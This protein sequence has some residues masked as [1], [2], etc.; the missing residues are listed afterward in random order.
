MILD[1]KKLA[2]KIKEGLKAEVVA[3]KTKYGVVPKIVNIMVGENPDSSAYMNSQRKAA[4]FVG[5]DY[6]LMSLPLDVTQEHLCSLI[7]ALNEDDRVTGVMITK[8]VPAHIHFSD[9]AN[10]IELN[11]D[12]EGINA[13]NIGN[14]LLGNPTLIPCTA[15]AVMEHLKSTGVDLSGKEVVIIGDS[16]IVGKPLSLLLLRELAT[17][18]V[19][20]IGTSRAGK[21]A[22]HV[23][24][25][26]V[27]IVA[28]GKAALVKGSWIKPGAIVIDVGINEVNG[29]IVGDVDFEDAQKRAAF[30]TPVPGGVGPVTSVML[31]RNSIEAFKLI[32]GV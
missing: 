30:I 18:T 25:A 8:P 7:L 23:E 4:G 16:Q 29:K 3:L 26:D 19:C 31:M 20:H 11:K 21:L 5:I 9:A 15:A 22:E 27:L 1:G 32:I 24:Q 28:V 2:Q 17:V 10:L 6:E 13:A 14:L 12:I